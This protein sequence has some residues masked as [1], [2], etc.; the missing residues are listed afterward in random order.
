MI[1]NEK[2]KRFES[3]L[4]LEQLV[5]ELRGESRVKEIELDYEVNFKEIDIEF[6]RFVNDPKIKKTLLDKFL[7]DFATS[8]L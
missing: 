4:T 2:I 7:V 1:E 5:Q 6:N 3:E 8:I